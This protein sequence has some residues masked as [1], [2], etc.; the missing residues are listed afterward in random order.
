MSSIF[1]I[2]SKRIK[3]LG[4]A[5]ANISNLIKENGFIFISDLCRS[6]S[7]DIAEHVEFRSRK[8]YEITLEEN[9]IEIIAICPLYYLLNR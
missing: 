3:H 1:Y 7:I 2:I 4:Q 8:I 6:K 5:I 9:G